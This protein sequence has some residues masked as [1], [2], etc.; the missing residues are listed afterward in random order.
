MFDQQDSGCVSYGIASDG[1]RWFVKT[2]T[3]EAAAAAL[4]R[5]IAVHAV[6]RHPAVVALRQICG[7]GD[8]RPVLLYPWVDGEVLYHPTAL[9]QPRRDDPASAWSRFR[10]QPR[11]VVESAVAALL[12]AH[13]AVTD[14]GFVAGDFYDGCLLWDAATRRLSLVDLDEYRPGPYVATF[15]PSGSRRFMAPEERR[16]G[17]ISVRTTVF[18]LGRAVR[19]MMD[20]G[21]T[22]DRWRGSAEQLAVVRRATA[23]DPAARH[24]DVRSL[25]AAW[26][27]A[28]LSG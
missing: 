5:A 28:S 10:R 23:A 16:G 8:G 14:V 21:D 11:G 13:V 12:A 3:D 24:P 17:V 22:E 7:D 9:G 20:H 15:D 25:L 19:L 6:V 4:Q 27:L 26:Q 1:D 2:A 18:G